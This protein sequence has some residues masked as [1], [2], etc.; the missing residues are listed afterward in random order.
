MFQ[1]NMDLDIRREDVGV[2]DAKSTKKTIFDSLQGDWQLWRTIRTAN[3]SYPSG[4]LTGTAKIEERPASEARFSHEC[5]YS[6]E[7]NFRTNKDFTVRVRRQYA[8]RYEQE[9]DKLTA[10]FVKSDESTSVDYLFHCLEFVNGT[11]TFHDRRSGKDGTVLIADGR[12][13]C[14]NDDYTSEY[15]FTLFGQE[16]AEWTVKYIVKGPQKDY[17]ARARYTRAG[18]EIGGLP[19]LT[20]D[21]DCL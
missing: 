8:Y 13:L 18:A 9:V 15:V 2:D 6:E 17:V 16:L 10:W 12:H 4:D 5:L 1:P 11:Q 20:K 19:K 3:P 7:G 14:G 21:G